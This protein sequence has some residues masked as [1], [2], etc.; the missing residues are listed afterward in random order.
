MRA[1]DECRHIARAAYARNG[2]LG[3]AVLVL[4]LLVAINLAVFPREPVAPYDWLTYEMLPDHL[5]NG[6]L[7]EIPWA[8]SPAAAW[9]MAA[10]LPIGYILWTALHIVVLPL[11]RDWRLILL[12]LMSMPFWLDAVLGHTTVFVLV[13]GAAALRG[14]RTG[15]LTSVALFL[16][17]PRP[18][19][20]PLLVWLLWKQPD[21]RVAVGVMASGMAV[22]TLASG[23]T[24][25]WIAATTSM[26][27]RY[28]DNAANY[29]PTRWLGLAWLLIGAPL[30][31]WLTRK[32]RVGLAGLALAP[33]VLPQYPL[34]L[35]WELIPRPLPAGVRDGRSAKPTRTMPTLPL[36]SH[37]TTIDANGSGPHTHAIEPTVTAMNRRRWSRMG[38]APVTE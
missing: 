29:S 26:T 22:V 11:L 8:W 30:A 4:G 16:L 17:A 14:S 31:A 21:I 10:I 24:T 35:I 18:V 15:T 34:L 5:E 20:A 27:S 32:G 1:I 13:T 2:D 25:E 33:Y 36:A 6:T 23:Y 38:R 9:T 7:Y 37:A 19:Q 3:R 28:L 12:T